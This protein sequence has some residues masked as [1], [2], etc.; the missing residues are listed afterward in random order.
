MSME[1]DKDARGAGPVRGPCQ[2]DPGG[3]VQEF[4]PRLA[5]EWLDPPVGKGSALSA[6]L[7]KER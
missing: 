4:T 5:G 6:P 2:S 1:R 3:F 7:K